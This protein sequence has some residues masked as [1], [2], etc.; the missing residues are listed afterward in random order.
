MAKRESTPAHPY[1]EIFALHE[2]KPLW[3]LS[4]R[5]KANGLREPIV[6]LEDKI[7]DGR[8]RELA[9]YRA[10]VEPKY[11][12]FGSRKED[13]KDPLEFV[14]D[15]NL[16]RRHLGEGEKALAAARYATAMGGRP[17]P[18]Q[19][20]EVS[21]NHTNSE[22]AEAFEVSERTVE[23]AKEVI[24]NGV[25]EVQEAL[26]K[27]EIT[28]SD[29]AK[30]SK[31]EPE[32]QREAVEAKRKGKAKS[33]AGAAKKKKE[34]DAKQNRNGKPEESDDEP[35]VDAWGIPITK[36]AETAFRNAD[37]FDELLKLLR[38]A[39]K[40]FKELAETEG[41][42]FLQQSFVSNNTRDG[43][44]H[45]GLDTCIKNVVDCKPKYTVCPYE[46]NKHLP[47]DKKNCKTCMGLGWTVNFNKSSQPGD[48]I[49]KA[50][51]KAHGVHS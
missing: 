22:A 19:V 11:R 45:A 29:A 28:V 47:H 36:E 4:D 21:D 46:Y 38:Q 9:C 20:G 17:K 27:D 23:R 15:I 40:M 31:E 30:V 49:I 26:E 25:P 41:G 10:G 2:G 5:I 3:E 48:D 42:Q 44:I 13:G 32:V 39:K 12:K 6:L 16:H 51:K 37:K 34:A 8:R 33:A 1:A 43:F 14:I 24:A 7:L 50:A 18:P 35:W